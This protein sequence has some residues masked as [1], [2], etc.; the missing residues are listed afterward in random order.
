MSRAR[1]RCGGFCLKLSSSSFA[2]FRCP[3][4]TSSSARM[5]L[6]V[7]F[8]FIQVSPCVLTLCQNFGDQGQFVIGER[9]QNRALSTELKSFWP[10]KTE[11][12]MTAFSFGEGAISWPR[13]P[14]CRNNAGRHEKAPAAFTCNDPRR[15]H[16]ERVGENQGEVST[17]IGN[18][19]SMGAISAAGCSRMT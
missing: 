16:A 7:L 2:S 19:V 5:G 9:P 8:S 3:P 1:R 13:S 14:N 15:G 10:S 17:A 4:I 12:C 6:S 18:G 11:S